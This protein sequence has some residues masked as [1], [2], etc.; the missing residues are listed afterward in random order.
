M[1][2]AGDLVMITG[3]DSDPL[4]VVTVV[5][6]H[7]DEF[8]FRWYRTVSDKRGHENHDEDFLVLV[9]CGN[10]DYGRSA[11]TDSGKCISGPGNWEVL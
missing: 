10:C 1:I 2:K 9:C 3:V 5:S 4:D 8:G 7:S 11:H 6:R